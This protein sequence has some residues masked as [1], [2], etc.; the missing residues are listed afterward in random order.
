MLTANVIF[1]LR[2]DE[3]FLHG[4]IRNQLS[5]YEKMNFKVHNWFVKQF[6]WLSFF[7]LCMGIPKTAA[8]NFGCVCSIRAGKML[9]SNIKWFNKKILK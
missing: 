9:K 3:H 7:V 1:M 2:N 4:K 5:G 8:N 6:M